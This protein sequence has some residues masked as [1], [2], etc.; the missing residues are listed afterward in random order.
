MNRAGIAV[1]RAFPLL[2][3]A[4]PELSQKNSG[5]LAPW[6]EINFPVLRPEGRHS[7]APSGEEA[8]P[9]ASYGGERRSFLLLLTV[10][11]TLFPLQGLS[12]TYAFPHTWGVRR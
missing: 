8:F 6:G 5:S 11:L 10:P 7:L 3:E 1:P 2:R 4:L 9:L 12:S